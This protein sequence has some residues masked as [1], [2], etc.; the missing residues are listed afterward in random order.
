[1][2]DEI[3]GAYRLDKTAI[4]IGDVDAPSDEPAYWATKTPEERMAALEFMRVIAYGYDP[5]TARLQRL[6]EVAEVADLT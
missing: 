2:R 4:S 6:L 1:M 3:L 5:A